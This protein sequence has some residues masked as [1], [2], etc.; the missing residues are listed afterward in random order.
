MADVN[1][2]SSL[3]LDNIKGGIT[4]IA[5]WVIWGVIIIAVLAFIWMKYQDK[6]VYIYPVRIH[7]QRNN[8]MVKEMNTF[9]GYIKKG[10]ITQFVIKMTRFK[11]KASNC[12]PDSSLMDEDNRVYYWQVSPESPLIQVKRTFT[13][14]KILVKNENFIEPTEEEKK[15]VISKWAK[16]L[17]EIEEWKDK[18]SEERKEEASIRY[19]EQLNLE[20]NKLIDITSP[21]YTPISTDLKQQALTDINNYKNTL[22]VDVNKQFA[23]FIMG[24]IAIIVLGIIIFYIAIN[25]GDLPILTE[26]IPLLFFWK[27][28]RKSK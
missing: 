5:V 1:L 27:R 15:E 14:E 3:G 22:G 11:K 20:R 24:V 12:L 7:R 10:Q 28:K 17:L 18:S 6:K 23:Y 25:K 26:Y 21:V 2:M 13:I 19:N 8:G 9:G 16:E 4:D